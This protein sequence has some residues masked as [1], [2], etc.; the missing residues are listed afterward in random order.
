V[1]SIT[2]FDLIQAPEPVTFTAHRHAALVCTMTCWLPVLV[3][4]VIELPDAA[5]EVTAG[6]APGD[7]PELTAKIWNA[8]AAAG[9]GVH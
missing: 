8:G 6:D 2:T 5:A 9:A 7:E 1:I 3:N 4:G